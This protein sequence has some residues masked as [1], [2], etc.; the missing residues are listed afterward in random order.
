METVYDYLTFGGKKND[1]V[2]P[3]YLQIIPGKKY[4]EKCFLSYRRPGQS[5]H[6]GD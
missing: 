4:I 1:T 6:C 3:E 5:C 2:M